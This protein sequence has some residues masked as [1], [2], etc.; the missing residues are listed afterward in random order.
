[1]ITTVV[2]DIEGTT[3]SIQFV[4][5]VLFPYAASHL[6]AFVREHGDEPAVRAH[7]D[8]AADLASI[9]RSDTQGVIAQLLQWIA[10]DR[11]VTPLKAL[12]GMIWKHGFETGAYQAHVY[13]D[14]ADK[15]T[16][17]QAQD[18]ALY[19][20]SSGSVQAQMLFFGHTARGD[21]RPLFR[22]YFDT[23]TGVKSAETSYRT[24]A[25]TIGRPPAEILFLSDVQA[26][27]DAASA[28]GLYTCWLIRPQDS[29]LDPTD[30]QSPHPIVTNF[31]PIRLESFA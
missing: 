19:V 17:W 6:S 2:T 13:T 21:M 3:S 7:L 15:L 28:A 23:T 9:A 18:V 20:Y 30:V 27:L 26:E 31:H 11:K 8:A 12:Q 16:E 25:H 14:A 10:D 1:M 5:E 22:G 24:I 4:K 29:S